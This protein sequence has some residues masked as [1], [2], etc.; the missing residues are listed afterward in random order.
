MF[1]EQRSHRSRQRFENFCSLG[2]RQVRD[3]SVKEAL[4][5]LMLTTERIHRKTQR[6]FLSWPDE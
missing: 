2:R 1:P 3:L 5:I 6:L 4:D